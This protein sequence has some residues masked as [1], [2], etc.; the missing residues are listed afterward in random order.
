MNFPW[1]KG[2]CQFLNIPTIYYHA[3]KSEKTSESFSRKNAKLTERFKYR[4]T[5]VI[6]QDPM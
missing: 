5:L 3:K 4:H 1:K 2:F 6:L